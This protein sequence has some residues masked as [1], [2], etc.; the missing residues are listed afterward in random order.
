MLKLHNVEI[1]EENTA[2]DPELL[3]EIMEKNEDVENCET[4]Q[5]LTEILDEMQENLRTMFIEFENRLK[6]DNLAGGREILI[7]MKYYF[8]IEN[9]IKSKLYNFK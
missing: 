4:K 8:S 3:L 2:L 5:E 9:S 7:K 1:P 6:Y